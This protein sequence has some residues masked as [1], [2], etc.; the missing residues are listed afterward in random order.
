ML[1]IQSLFADDTSV[2]SIK[3]LIYFVKGTQMYPLGMTTIEKD[4][5]TPQDAFR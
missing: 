2:L 1:L 5:F 4:N 3:D